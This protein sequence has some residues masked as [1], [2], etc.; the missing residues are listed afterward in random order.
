MVPVRMSLLITRSYL[1]VSATYG[2]G[3]RTND[4]PRTAHTHR[5]PPPPFLWGNSHI[6]WVTG[7]TSLLF[8]LPNSVSAAGGIRRY[9]RVL[10]VHDF[11]TGLVAFVVPVFEPPVSGRMR[12][13]VAVG[14]I[15]REG[16]ISR[17]RPSPASSY[18]QRRPRQYK[19]RTSHLEA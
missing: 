7:M 14:V 17:L 16:G 15:C 1:G 5:S 11:S 18:A 13:Q 9:E 12:Q 19:R 4:V 6:H 10:F 8:C 3:L 2:C